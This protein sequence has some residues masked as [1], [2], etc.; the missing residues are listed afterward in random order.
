MLSPSASADYTTIQIFHTH[1]EG[2]VVAIGY[3]GSD[4]YAAD[5]VTSILDNGPRGRWSAVLQMF[6]MIGHLPDES[7]KFLHFNTN[8]ASKYSN[9]FIF[10]R[11]L[12]ETINHR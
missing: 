6:S 11:H 12:D 3:I 8:F 9:C 2:V 7:S 5:Y 10:L 1:L 4:D